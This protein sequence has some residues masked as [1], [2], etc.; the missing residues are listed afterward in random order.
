MGLWLKNKKESEIKNLS[1]FILYSLFKIPQDSSLPVSN[2][3]H[4]IFLWFQYLQNVQICTTV[5]QKYM[6]QL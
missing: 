5:Y 4:D 6:L 3:K 1:D 2:V